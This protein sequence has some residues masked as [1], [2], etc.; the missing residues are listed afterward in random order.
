MSRWERLSHAFAPPCAH[1]DASV[2]VILADQPG[3]RALFHPSLHLPLSCGACPRLPTRHHGV[4][5][6]LPRVSAWW[7]MHYCAAAC[8]R[9]A[10]FSRKPRETTDNREPRETEP[11][12]SV[13]ETKRT[14]LFKCLREKIVRHRKVWT[15]RATWRQSL[16]LSLSLSLSYSE[17]LDS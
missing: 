9:T 7:R 14:K 8:C 17:T 10:I 16:S 1:R 11:A 12:S 15:T 6:P 3:T 4:Q 2:R 5:Q 13:M